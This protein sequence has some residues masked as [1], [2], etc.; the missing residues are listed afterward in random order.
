MTPSYSS[1]KKVVLETPNDHAPS[2]Q[3]NNWCQSCP[4]YDE[5]SWK[6]MM[7]RSQLETKYR[8][9]I[10]TD[11]NSEHYGKQKNYCSKLYIKEWKI[12]YS[13]LYLKQCANNK[14]FWQSMKPFLS[15]K[16]KVTEKI[17]V[18]SDNKIFSYDL[19]I[20]EKFN[21]FFINA[22]NNLNLSSNEDLLLSAMHIS[23][24]VQIAIA[25]MF[26]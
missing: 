19:E 6:A 24:P 2:K 1:F 14:T 18:V 22:V 20:A 11:I 16:N 8:K 21:E 5:N 7:H 26:C 25:V 23:D 10:L 4:L 13:N 3:K 15:D 12:Y 9:Q 17:T